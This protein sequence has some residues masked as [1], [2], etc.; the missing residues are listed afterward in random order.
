MNA[1]LPHVAFPF[2][3]H[4]QP[5]IQ[6]RTNEDDATCEKSKTQF[7]Y[8]TGYVHLDKLRVCSRTIRT[9]LGSWKRKSERL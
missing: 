3:K 2:C 4:T 1:E 8:S 6:S 9:S 5:I 7:P